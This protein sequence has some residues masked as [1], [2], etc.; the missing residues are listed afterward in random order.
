V[1]QAGIAGSTKLGNNVTVGGQTGLAGHL[2]IG[3]NVLISSQSGIGGDISDGNQVGGN[4]SAPLRES[5]K[6][7]ALI[8]KLPEI[9][10]SL[11]EIKNKIEGKI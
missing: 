3:N 6:I 10:K 5:I 1:A 11:K 9:Y 8:R 7:R 4:P 2:K